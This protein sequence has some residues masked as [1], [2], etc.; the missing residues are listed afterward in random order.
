MSDNSLYTLSNSRKK[1]MTLKQNAMGNKLKFLLL[2][3]LTASCKYEE[4]PLFS[5]V[6]VPD[7]VKGYY[8]LDCVE[9]NGINQMDR[10]DT[11]HITS[12][13]FGTG[14]D[15]HYANYDFEISIA[16]TITYFSEWGVYNNNSKLFVDEFGCRGYFPPDTAP[17]FQP[18]PGFIAG[19][20]TNPNAEW[21]II[22]LT[23]K[24]LWLKTTLN[25]NNYEVHFKQTQS[26]K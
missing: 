24:K 4:G 12:V 23:Q 18:L 8:E 9:E 26:A 2:L 15:L 7:R 19:G 17:P 1:L 25:G 14:S 16:D 11:I 6:S 22:K 21:T 10:I 13:Y 20:C 5:L 3:L